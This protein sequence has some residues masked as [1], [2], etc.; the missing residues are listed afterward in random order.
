MHLFFF[1]VSANNNILMLQLSLAAAESFSSVPV[2]VG[3]VP[4]LIENIHA[5]SAERFGTE[6]NIHPLLY[7]FLFFFSQPYSSAFMI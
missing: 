3:A 6:L 1:L 5:D 4:F 7:D 2:R